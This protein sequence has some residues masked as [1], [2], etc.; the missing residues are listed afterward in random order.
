MK[1]SKGPV[2]T[3]QVIRVLFLAEKWCFIIHLCLG[4]WGDERFPADVQ[5]QGLP[6][7]MLSTK[8]GTAVET[9]ACPL[10]AATANR[11]MFHQVYSP[12]DMTER[13][14]H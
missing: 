5:R 4:L 2:R 12:K 14:L 11:Q 1:G 6:K 8:I 9:A 3:G 13:I 7:G 10:C